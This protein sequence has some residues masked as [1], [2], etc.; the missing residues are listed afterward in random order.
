MKK[1]LLK[2]FKIGIVFV[3]ACIFLA[4]IFLFSYIYF[5]PE[6]IDYEKLDQKETN[7]E[8]FDQNLN[9]M[10]LSIDKYIQYEDLNEYTKNAFIATEDKRFYKHNGV[11]YIRVVGALFN[12]LKTGSSQ[13]GSTITQQLVK[14]TFLS[15][16]K[17]ISRK[18]KEMNM[19]IQLEKEYS[20][21]E[22]LEKYLNIL[23]FGSGEYGIAN[24]SKRFF[25]KE[26]KDLSL[27]ESASLACI[28]KSPTKYNLI[29]NYENNS[30]RTDL[31]LKLM[32]N[33]NKIT[34]DEYNK[35]LNETIIIKNVL[36]KNNYNSK[37][38]ENALI[39]SKNVL[40]CNDEDFYYSKYKIY[41]YADTNVQKY[42]SDS[43]TNS[44]KTQESLKNINSCYIVLNNK[45]HGI[46]AISYT[47]NDNIYDFKRSPGSTIKPIAVYSP[48]I[49]EKIVL[50]ENLISNLK[51]DFNGYSPSNYKDIYTD[52]VTVKQALSCS[53][54]V[55]S[56]SLL[57]MLGISKCKDYL[58][59]MSININKNDENL[60][61][62]LGGMTYGI[63][64][65]DLISSYSVYSNNGIY[66]P[67]S[68]IYKIEDE[69]G[70]ILY[71]NNSTGNKVFED[72]TIYLT[73]EMLKDAV[74]SG[75]ANKLK[76]LNFP[77]YAKTGTV[78]CK[79]SDKNTD[80]YNISY[81]KN[82]TILS[83]IGSNNENLLESN[84]TGGGIPTLISRNILKF[85]YKDNLPQD[86]D[87]PD[88]IDFKEFD[89]IELAKNNYVYADDIAPKSTK[90]LL[91]TPIDVDFDKDLSF[92]NML[93]IDINCLRCD[94]YNL[95]TFIPNE[96]ISYKI[97]KRQ[98]FIEETVDEIKNSSLPYT[99][100]ID[101]NEFDS[102][103]YIIPYYLNDNG[104]ECFENIIY[105]N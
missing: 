49:N 78:S 30:K 63:N 96:R 26:V 85:L 68:F 31:V 77:V 87:I 12:N 98:M 16:N 92:S 39:Q 43:I 67:S 32:Y 86:F 72:S 80:A 9:K 95:Y 89:K 48:S 47:M 17:T 97:I 64:F 35:A 94:D 73:N 60:A 19:A 93:N 28:I 57:K 81:T 27:R 3:L 62:A 29:N 20:K 44:Y 45:N 75:T 40:N 8:V 69:N 84:I 50:P 52:K 61:L 7:I 82:H 104:I 22:I 83:W 90:K 76:N 70:E 71:K 37:Y 54:N 79:N 18:L 66:Y 105:L 15:S 99:L 14:N 10:E 53:Y 65:I 56:V 46:E 74:F 88:T 6:N 34:E 2:I 23:Y 4:L 101:N 55:P 100:K 25:D 33:Q 58:S 102:I 5:C 21:E 1:K 36:N 42:L 11:D 13:G 59:K 103:Y 41:T 91:P 24:A 51:T 38:L